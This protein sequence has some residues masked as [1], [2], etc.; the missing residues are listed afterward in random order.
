MARRKPQV[1]KVDEN[2]E[3]IVSHL[4]KFWKVEILAGVKFGCP[5]LLVSVEGLYLLLEVKMPGERL[6]ERQQKWLAKWYGPV[7]VVHSPE[8]AFDVCM[9][10]VAAARAHRAN[11]EHKA[12]TY[13]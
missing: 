6:N 11:W 12:V 5:D 3:P 10:A 2:Q 13:G 1:C 4:R 8:E 7:H 9:D